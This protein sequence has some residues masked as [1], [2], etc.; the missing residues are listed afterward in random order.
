MECRSSRERLYSCAA[1]ICVCQVHSHNVRP[2]KSLKSLGTYGG[3]SLTHEPLHLL[4]PIKENQNACQRNKWRHILSSHSGSD[5]LK[6]EFNSLP[7]IN[8]TTRF[9]LVKIKWPKQPEMFT[10]GTLVEAG[11]GDQVS[12][13]FRNHRR[14][15]RLITPSSLAATFGRV[16]APLGCSIT[17]QCVLLQ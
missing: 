5:K 3:L 1:H 7:W 16:S 13:L 6:E 14:P 4:R 9:K 10:C 11:W 17:P 8:A 2:H 15:M 12:Q